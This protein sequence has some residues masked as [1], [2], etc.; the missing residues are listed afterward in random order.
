M[1]FDGDNLFIAA[2]SLGGVM[3]QK[4]VKG[5]T[6][7]KGQILMGSVVLRADRSLNDQGESEFSQTVPTLTISGT[8]D[9]LL[10]VSR[11]AESYWHQYT[12]IKSDQAGMFPVLVLEGVSHARFM[13]DSMIPSYVTKNDLNPE[14]S[15]EIAH[16]EIS[17]GIVGLID[18]VLKSSSFDNE[19]TEAILKPLI[20]GMILENSYQ[21][22]DPCYAHDLVNPTDNP[23]CSAGSP[24]VETAQ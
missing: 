14:I 11:A 21:M 5:K 2:H 6:N 22:K 20:D 15:Q 1:G 23:K 13:D 24:W 12:N 18:Q 9:G 16:Q 7:F 4:Y 10:R 3:S 8:K 19:N 17:K